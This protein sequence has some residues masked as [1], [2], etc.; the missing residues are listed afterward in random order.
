MTIELNWILKNKKSLDLTDEVVGVYFLIK[1]DEIVYVGSSEQ[2]CMNRIMTHIKEGNK[3]FDS[4]FIL[5]TKLE[6]AR[7]QE[8]KF[9]MELTPKY[10]KTISNCKGDIKSIGGIGKTVKNQSLKAYISIIN[11]VAY[12]DM[13]KVLESLEAE[14]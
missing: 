12:I 8:I 11:S 9:I 10:N 1:E 2:S 6:D 5:K 3:D 14:E 4:Y 7:D 13:S